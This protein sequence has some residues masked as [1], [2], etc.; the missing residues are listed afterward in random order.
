VLFDSATESLGNS[1]IDNP[2]DEIDGDN[3]VDHGEAEADLILEDL[4]RSLGPLGFSAVQSEEE[5]VVKV[6]EPEPAIIPEIEDHDEF[7]MLD[8]FIDK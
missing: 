5:E 8:D 3:A 1:L 6:A 2:A 4:N 7:K